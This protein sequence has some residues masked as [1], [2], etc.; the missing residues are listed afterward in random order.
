MRAVVFHEHGDPDVLTADEVDTPKPG[1]GEVLVDVAACGINRVDLWT[2]QGGPHVDLPLPHVLGADV[3]GTVAAA[4][5]V[6][7]WSTGDRV[8][9]NP[10]LSCGA[11]RACVAGDHSL[12]PGFEL[13]GEHRWGGY[14]EQVVVP[15]VNLHPLPDGVE[16]TTVAAA[17]VVT[18]TAWR[19]LRTRAPVGPGDRVLVVGATGGVGSTAVQVAKASGAT[20]FGTTRD[21]DRVD[22]LRGIGVDEPVVIDEEGAFHRDVLSRTDGEGVDVVVENVGEAAWKPALKSA[23]KG[24]T[25]VTCGATTGYDPGAGLNYV[26]WKQLDV[27]GSTMGSRAEFTDAIE[28]VVDG[29]IDPVVDRVLPLEEAADAH[30]AIED[31]DVFGKVVLEI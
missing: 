9:V 23:A 6:D 30:R 15:A 1:P 12:C 25:I 24:G 3:V 31:G 16:E 4:E 2:R 27:K 18:V 17:P 20:V 28:Q 10:G 8:V 29:P 11:C 22:E 21:P 5:G 7:G 19:M 14:A 13:L 26:F